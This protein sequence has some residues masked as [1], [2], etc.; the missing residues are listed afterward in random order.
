MAR[1]VGHPSQMRKIVRLI[2]VTIAGGLILAIAAGV[3][4]EFFIELARECGWYDNPSERLD[5]T[6]S[7]F[8][9]FV[10]HP[11]F[12]ALAAGFF[13]LAV[14]AWL[15]LFL[16]RRETV[17][18]V[19][20]LPPEPAREGNRHDILPVRALAD[21]TDIQDLEYF[22]KLYFYEAY[23]LAREQ[24]VV[25]VHGIT[26][27]SHGAL[28]SHYKNLVY[29]V[30]RLGDPIPFVNFELTLEVSLVGQTD[31][32]LAQDKLSELYQ[33]YTLIVSCLHNVADIRQLN[34]SDDHDYREWI[35]RHSTLIEQIE[36]MTAQSR[37][38][39][40]DMTVR[41][42]RPFKPRPYS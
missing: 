33:R 23:R 13:G 9:S 14:G 16:R 25:A 26:L 40:L 38:K 41:Q 17:V 21:D 18:S 6:V 15:D 35:E 28:G 37:Y 12:I 34:L 20:E 42:I 27:E 39:R 36:R 31:A 3:I 10:T 32:S 2:R 5:A 19:A 4:G 11:W 8:S 1:G 22:I 7:A 24:L 29:R 30:C